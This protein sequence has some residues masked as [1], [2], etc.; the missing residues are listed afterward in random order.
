MTG[1]SAHP[2]PLDFVRI[3]CGIGVLPQLQILHVPGFPLPPALFPAWQPV[4]H[5]IDDVLRVAGEQDAIG[6]PS[7]RDLPECFN[8]RAEGHA[9]VCSRWLG[10]PV[11]ATRNP[12][13]AW[14]QPLDQTAGAAG[15]LTVAPVAET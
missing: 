7:T 5:P 10:D 1:V 6:V 14:V 2:A 12:L 13:R 9:V 8:H 4:G 15:V 11:V 3:G